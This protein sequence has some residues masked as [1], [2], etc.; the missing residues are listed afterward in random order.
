MVINVIGLDSTACIDY[1]NGRKAVKKLLEQHDE[2]V[3][4]TVIT[5]YEVN[6][7]LE[8]TK[9]KI[10]EKRY[11]ELNEKWLEFISGMEILVMDSKEAVIAAEIHD[12]LK[13]KGTVIDDNDILIASIFLS[14]NIPKIVTRNVKHFHN[15][16][17]LNVIGYTL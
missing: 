13:S 1:L 4:I 6:I 2:M 10:S 16:D 17:R 7:G 14:N 8:R 5:I 3:C 12:N 11:K 9:R 15:I